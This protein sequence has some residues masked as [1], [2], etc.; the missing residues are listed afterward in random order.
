MAKRGE[1]RV[2]E[3]FAGVGGFRLGLEGI[4]SKDF[5]LSGASKKFKTVWAN[6]WEPGKSKQHAV[7]IYRNRFGENANM[8]NKDVATVIDDVPAHELLVGGFPCQDYSVAHT[9]A[10]GLEGKKGVLWWSIDK[11]VAARRPPYIL[12]ENVDRLVKSPASQ[13]GRDFGI[14]LRCLLDKGYAVEWRIVNAAEYGQAQR[15]RRTFIF[16]YHKTTAFY[17]KLARQFRTYQDDALINAIYKDGF[18]AKVFPVEMKMADKDLNKVTRAAIGIDDYSDLAKVSGE[19]KAQFYSSGIM[20]EGRVWSLETT[21]KHVAPIIMRETREAG[22]VDAKYFLGANLGQWKYLKGAKS[23]DR[24]DKKTGYAYKFTEGPVAFPDS[25]DKPSRTML[26]SES[27]V[28]RSTHVIEDA[29]TGK[30][31]LLTPVECERLNGFPD[32]WTAVETVPEKFRYFAM[33]N[34]LVVPLIKM[35]GKEIESLVGDSSSKPLKLINSVLKYF[36]E[37]RAQTGVDE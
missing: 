30:L 33:G 7:T 15:R 25:L 27:S 4:K 18:F 10:Q 32:G 21:P 9:G 31:R 1:I 19:F 34:A 23:E 3:L 22:A 6:Q 29:K 26:T 13:R 8:V 16:A 35:M 2:V 11:I 24:V 36:A 20:F 12:L 17:K 14:I 5:N 28:N 37:L